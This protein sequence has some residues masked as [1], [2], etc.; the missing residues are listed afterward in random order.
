MQVLKE[1]RGCSEL[2]RNRAL[3][4]WGRVLRPGPRS[5]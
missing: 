2:G 4:T 5:A 1:C 3:G